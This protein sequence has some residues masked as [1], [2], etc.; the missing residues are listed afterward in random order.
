MFMKFKGFSKLIN[1]MFNELKFSERSERKHTQKI[2][3]MMNNLTI[4]L[5]LKTLLPSPHQ[6]F[7]F[8]VAK[9]IFKVAKMCVCVCVCVFVFFSVVSKFF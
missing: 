8:F 4:M 1:Y 9:F 7:F 3:L 6:V 2:D 5:L